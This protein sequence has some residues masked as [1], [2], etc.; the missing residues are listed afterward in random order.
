[1]PDTA[2]LGDSKR[3]PTV[4][5][6]LR[7]LDNSEQNCVVNLLGTALDHRPGFFME[8]LP[9]LLKQRIHTGRPHW[10]L[11]DEAHHLLPA[12][13]EASLP[14]IPGDLHGGVMLVT[15]HP[16]H[17]AGAMLS[18]VDLVLAIGASPGETLAGFSRAL[19]Q[20]PPQVRSSPLQ[21]GEAIA[22]WRRQGTEPFKFRS[23]PP[24]AEHDRHVRKYA[25]G[26]LG[27]D[28]SFYFRG[29][30]GKL[31]LR[32]QNLMLFLQLA[33]GVDDRTWLY[34][35]SRGDYSRWLREAIKDSDLAAEVQ[36]IERRAG[37]SAEE[38]RA[39]IKERIESRYTIPA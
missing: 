24:R 17:V 14:N 13:R 35:L 18:S 10:I 27:L 5:E 11:I 30:E 31:N 2:L 33:E 7:L 39:L 21:P 36:G 37:I 3:T 16:E 4:E 19:G 12:S 9:A 15:V 6:V 23:I 22:W 34:H 25:E 1:M 28:R 29:P 26:A 8:L 20:V 32:A 38:S